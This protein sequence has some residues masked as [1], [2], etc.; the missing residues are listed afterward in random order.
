LLA[1][2][3]LA[4]HQAQTRVAGLKAAENLRQAAI[5]HGP[6][7]ADLQLARLAFGHVARLSG[8]GAG[9]GQQGSGG[10]HKGQARRRELH[11]PAVSI[12]QLRTHRSFELLD[13]QAQRRL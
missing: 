1:G 11:T 9:L 10:R 13:V 3:Q 12:E 2:T 8:S 5:Q 7:K 6:G 4:Q